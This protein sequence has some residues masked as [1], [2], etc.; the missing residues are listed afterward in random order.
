MDCVPDATNRCTRCGWQQKG[1]G[2]FVRRNCRKPE[3]PEAR[4]KREAEIAKAESAYV[5]RID[6][7][8]LE[9]AGHYA[10]ALLRW[11]A[12]GFPRRSDEEV[13]AIVAIC[14]A[15]EKFRD[16]ACTKCGCGV[17]T[18]RWAVVNKARMATEICS[19]GKW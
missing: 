4:A 19:L 13:A 15:C 18:S 11:S 1:S 5:E 2:K 6:P 16:G 14:R 17:S 3:T 10:V 9:K 12:A 8:P 7:T